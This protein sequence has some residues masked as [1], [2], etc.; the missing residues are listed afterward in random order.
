MSLTR[1]FARHKI[2]IAFIFAILVLLAAGVSS[3]RALESRQTSV[4][5]VRHTYNVIGAIDDLIE[6]RSQLF[7][8][9]GAVLR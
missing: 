7:I 4:G 5:W 1:L 3:Y 9:A 2:E 6:T 8:R